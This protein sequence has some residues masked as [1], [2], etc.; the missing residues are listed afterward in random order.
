[1]SPWRVVSTPES[2][3]VVPSARNG[4]L[5]L[6]INIF[7][8]AGMYWLANHALEIEDKTGLMV[9]NLICITTPLLMALG[10]GIWWM[11]RDKLP[12]L[13]IDLRTNAVSLPRSAVEFPMYSTDAVFVYDI[14]S[15]RGDDTVCEFNLLL[16]RD[17]ETITHPIFHNLG[18]SSAYAKL[19]RTLQ[20]AGLRFETRK[21][22]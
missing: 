18:Q 19:G 15:A 6:L 22:K 5:T 20:A 10:M 16:T 12:H 3:A 8:G 17:Q 13:I 2:I 21:S 9:W 1:M 7:G 14:I 4:V 11:F